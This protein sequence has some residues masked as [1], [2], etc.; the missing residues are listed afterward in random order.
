MVELDPIIYQS[1]LA[2]AFD[3][4]TRTVYMIFCTVYMYDDNDF[5]LFFF[6]MIFICGSFF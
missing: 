5:I 2:L 4:D 1:G 3:V 6:V